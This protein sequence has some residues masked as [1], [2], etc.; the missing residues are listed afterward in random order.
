M[1]KLK[2]YVQGWKRIFIKECL[3]S[4]SKVRSSCGSKPH[5]ISGEIEL[6]SVKLKRKI[7]Q[8]VRVIVYG[9][10]RDVSRS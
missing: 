10:R 4:G 8:K 7:G 3:V 6:N 5:K 9:R 1:P 2:T